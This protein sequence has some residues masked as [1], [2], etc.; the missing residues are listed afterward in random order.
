LGGSENKRDEAGGAGGGVDE[1]AG[2][3]R[4]ATPRRKRG[5][6]RK[7]TQKGNSHAQHQHKDARK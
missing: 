6:E 7:G 2:K 5:N 3:R 1:V 4:D